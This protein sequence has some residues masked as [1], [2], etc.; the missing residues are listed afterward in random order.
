LREEFL[1][2][3]TTGNPVEVS[4]AL[5]FLNPGVSVGGGLDLFALAVLPALAQIRRTTRYRL[6]RGRLSHT[7]TGEPPN[8]AIVKPAASSSLTS[9]AFC[10]AVHSTSGG[11]TVVHDE[12]L[13]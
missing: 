11:R 4:S 10:S 13:L 12:S 8:P 7:A 3:V 2:R 5:G 9:E 1:D 6:T